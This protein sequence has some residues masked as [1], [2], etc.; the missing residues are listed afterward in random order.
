MRVRSGLRPTLGR[1]EIARAGDR[2][3]S[4]LLRTAWRFI[5]VNRDFQPG[6]INLVAKYLGATSFETSSDRFTVRVV[7]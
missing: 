4:D 2:V 1:V 7:R 6:R 3:G 5:R